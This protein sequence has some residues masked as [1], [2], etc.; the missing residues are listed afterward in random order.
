[1]R[2][3]QGKQLP[4]VRVQMVDQEANKHE[5]E[6][7]DQL[8]KQKQPLVKVNGQWVHLQKGAIEEA[9]KLFTDGDVTNM[10][11]VEALRLAQGDSDA[12]KTL[13]IGGMTATGWVKE[14]IESTTDS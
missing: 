4:T 8:L 11:L 9:K 3:E 12:L 5:R 2:D 13:T 10:P 14:L 7:F 1:M 6:E